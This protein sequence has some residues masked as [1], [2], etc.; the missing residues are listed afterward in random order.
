MVVNA[1]QLIRTDPKLKE[2]YEEYKKN[3]YKLTDDPRWT[4]VGKFIRKYSIDEIPSMINV[5]KGEM[6]LVGPRPYYFDE[7][8]EQQKKFPYTKDLVKI[9]LTQKPGVTGDWQVS[10]RS[11]IN[12]DKRI[13][14]DATYVN[15]RSTAHDLAIILKTPWAM[16]SGRGAV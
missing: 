10:G 4:R 1:H 15:R 16:I 3:S 5:L 7:I 13:E 12:F 6:S 8:E 2:L 9:V 11:E 14:M